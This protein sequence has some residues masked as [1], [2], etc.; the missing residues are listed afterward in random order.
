MSRQAPSC[1]LVTR[2]LREFS[3][4]EISSGFASMFEAGN[5]NNEF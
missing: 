3:D 5:D 2:G 4:I 1:Q